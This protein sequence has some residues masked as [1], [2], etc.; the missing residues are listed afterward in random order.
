MKLGVDYEAVRLLGEQLYSQ[1]RQLVFLREGMQN[2][3]DSGAK[4]IKVTIDALS[5]ETDIRIEDD[6]CGISDFQSLFLTIGGSSKRSGGTIGGYG[7]AKMAIL[8]MD[9]WQIQS[10]DGY[11][12][13]SNLIDDTDHDKTATCE[14]CVLSGKVQDRWWYALEEAKDYLSLI[15][16]PDDVFIYLNGELIEQYPTGR[17]YLP[18]NLSL[19]KVHED[20][21]GMRLWSSTIVVRLNGLPQFDECFY[22]YNEYGVFIHDIQTDYQSYDNQYPMMPN[23]ESFKESSDDRDHYRD[24]RTKFTKMLDD[25]NI[26]EKERQ[27]NIRLIGKNLLGGEMNSELWRENTELFRMFKRYCKAVMVLGNYKPSEYKFGMTI[28]DGEYDCY[29]SKKK[30]FML[31]PMSVID[32]GTPSVLSMA[33][34]NVAHIAE[35]GHYERW[36]KK[37]TELTTMVL[38]AVIL[39]T[40]KL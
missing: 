4:N 12:N 36:G 35:T 1:P 25:D 14:G 28:K 30:I 17:V 5:Y 32:K 8:A 31:D 15:S 38:N 22:G 34:H 39:G 27:L 7:I 9:D 18:D 6:G 40:F 29:D 33:I 13:K 20:N 10:L 11:L 24:V 2:A 23:R 3:I 19:L 21:D 26:A 16:V 37:C